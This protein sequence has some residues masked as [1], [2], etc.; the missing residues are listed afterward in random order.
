VVELDRLHM[1]MSRCVPVATNTD[2]Q[3]VIVFASPLQKLLLE[4]ASLL[5]SLVMLLNILLYIFL[6]DI[7]F[8]SMRYI[9]QYNIFRFKNRSSS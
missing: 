2:L 6:S 8:Y 9:S 1:R 3:Y 4:P 7:C 5:H